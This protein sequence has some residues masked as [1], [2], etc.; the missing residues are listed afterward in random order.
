M[1]VWDLNASL[2]LIEH[3]YVGG[4]GSLLMRD[5]PF[6]ENLL[7]ENSVWHKG[8]GA[9]TKLGKVMGS[10]F[11]GRCER[12]GGLFSFMLKYL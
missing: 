7:A 8:A 9:L 12:S 5:T 11:R 10:V 2:I 3:S 4:C 6:G 1:M